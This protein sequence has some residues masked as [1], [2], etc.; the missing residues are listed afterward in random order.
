MTEIVD[1]VLADGEADWTILEIDG[2]EETVRK[3]AR[4]VA[5]QYDAVEFEDMVQEG[6]IRLATHAPEVRRVVTDGGLGGVHHWV[7]CDLTNIA[8]RHA[9]R[10][11]RNV[12]HEMLLERAGE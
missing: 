12:S 3:A 7:W 8:D 9:R 2:I 4:K 11:N 1:V 6:L 5:G 10:T